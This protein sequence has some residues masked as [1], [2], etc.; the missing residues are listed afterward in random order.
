MNFSVL[1]FLG[2]AMGI[3]IPG[4]DSPGTSAQGHA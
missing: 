3:V 4:T 2:A 1:K